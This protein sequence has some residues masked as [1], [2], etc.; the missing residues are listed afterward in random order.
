MFISS[1]LL[2]VHIHL[3]LTFLAT[4]HKHPLAAFPTNV[5]K[6]IFVFFM[7]ARERQRLWK[8]RSWITSK[9]HETGNSLQRTHLV[10]I[11]RAEHLLNVLIGLW[12][13]PSK[14][15]ELLKFMLCQLSRRTLR[16]E[17]LV[18]VVDL[19]SLQII[20]GGAAVVSHMYLWSEGWC[21]RND[22]LPPVALT[23]LPVCS[24]PCSTPMSVTWRI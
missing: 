11:K 17:F 3:F 4:L 12:I 7:F 15:K 22:P 5:C 23:A 9:Q 20:H 19:D 1:V 18:P 16:H 24:C 8:C 13:Q 2:P 21:D 6:R 14:S 10:H